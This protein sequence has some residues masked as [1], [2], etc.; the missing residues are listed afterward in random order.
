MHVAASELRVG[1]YIWRA[2][3]AVETVES[4]G[5]TVHTTGESPTL[6]LTDHAYFLVEDTVRIAR[7]S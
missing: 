5:V 7:A 1:D 4:T 6:P 3:F 2:R